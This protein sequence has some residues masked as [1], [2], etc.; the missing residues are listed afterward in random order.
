MFNAPKEMPKVIRSPQDAYDLLR[1]EI[2]YL[3]YEVFVAIFLNTKNGV[4]GWEVLS[5]GSL[6]ASIVHPREVF[7]K[8]VQY[9]S[10]SILVGHNHPSN[11]PTPSPE[12]LRMT[13]RLVQAGN[14]M[15][16]EVLDHII[17]CADRYISF[18][19]QGHL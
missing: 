4:L 15:G 2:G 6:N 17:V 1:F 12:D 14:I 16:I 18:K 10:A 9:S 3:Q 8:S 19:E 13:E 11:D 5:Q 7:K